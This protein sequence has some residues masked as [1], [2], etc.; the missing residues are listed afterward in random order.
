MFRRIFTVGYD[1]CSKS[2]PKYGKKSIPFLR[3]TGIWLTRRAGLTVGDKVL[4]LAE[5]GKMAVIKIEKGGK[6]GDA[7]ADKG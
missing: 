3:F 4:V 1:P 2:S 7:G 6:G 5:A